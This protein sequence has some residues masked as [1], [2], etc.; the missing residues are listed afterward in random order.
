MSI[1]KF[2]VSP[3]SAS[4]A[5]VLLFAFALVLMSPTASISQDYKTL[6]EGKTWRWSLETRD[7]D[8]GGKDC[9]AFVC[10]TR[11]CSKGTINMELYIRGTVSTGRIEPFFRARFTMLG[12]ENPRVEINGLSYP[13]KRLNDGGYFW[14]KSRTDDKKIMNALLD[15]EDGTIVFRD[16]TSSEKL[17]VKGFGPVQEYFKTQCKLQL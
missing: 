17:R 6:Y 12:A 16:D 2:M 5:L 3:N 10:N 8:R 11:D 4:R 1:L 7:Y 13:L 14:A 9:R 15:L